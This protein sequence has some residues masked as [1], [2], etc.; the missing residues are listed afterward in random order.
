M[1][2]KNIMRLHTHILMQKTW[3]FLR[4]NRYLNG[5]ESK[6]EFEAEFENLGQVSG[7]VE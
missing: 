2:R 3:R 4:D 7:G 6:E 1:K 5:F